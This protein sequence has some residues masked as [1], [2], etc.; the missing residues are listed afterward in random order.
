MDTLRRRAQQIT[1]PEPDIEPESDDALVARAQT[2]PNAFADLWERYYDRVF[3]F[4]RYR[5]P[6]R[7]DAEDA[8]NEIFKNAFTALATHRAGESQFRPWLFAIARN[9]VTGAHRRRGLRRFLPFSDLLDHASIEP[10]PEKRA[11]L[12]DEWERVFMLL[13]EFPADQR[14]VLEL[15]WSGLSGREVAKVLGK[16]E[17][18]IRKV[19]SRARERLQRLYEKEARDDE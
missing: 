18:A 9:E 17:D 4:C 3:R 6:T 10:S 12:N 19:E 13:Q 5:L 7:E 16:R 11:E 2:D 15:R 14:R 8:A 1:V